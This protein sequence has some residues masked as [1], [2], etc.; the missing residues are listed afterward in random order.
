MIKHYKTPEDCWDAYNQGNLSPEEEAFLKKEL[1]DKHA[2]REAFQEQ[3]TLSEA[4]KKHN[5]EQFKARFQQSIELAEKTR[6]SNDKLRPFLWAIIIAASFLGAYYFYQ[7]YQYWN[8]I[9]ENIA[10]VLQDYD[11]TYMGDEGIQL[12]PNELAMEK[13]IQLLKEK[14]YQA[15]IFEFKKVKKISPEEYDDYFSAQFRIASAYIKLRDKQ[16]AKKTL[17]DLINQPEKHFLKGK[18]VELLKGL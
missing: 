4:V 14:E 15:A 2:F 16:K 6:R 11:P 3:R 5:R 12:T 1:R 9:E 10:D 13:G 8:R 18:A 7:S 17:Q